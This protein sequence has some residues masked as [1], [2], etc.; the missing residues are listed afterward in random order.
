MPDSS[1]AFAAKQLPGILQNLRANSDAKIPKDY[2]LSDHA[3][4]RTVL[5]MELDALVEQ[6]NKVLKDVPFGGWDP[7]EKAAYDGRA[8]RIA[9]LRTE[10][11]PVNGTKSLSN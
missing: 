7:Q 5:I 3:N 2:P 6:Q 9:A 4:C 8:R 1:N 11:F 10:L